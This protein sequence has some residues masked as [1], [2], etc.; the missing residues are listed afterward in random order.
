MQWFF[1]SHVNLTY[2]QKEIIITESTEKANSAKNINISY[3]HFSQNKK[4]RK[5]AL[6]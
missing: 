1:S 6:K 3:K 4:K 5:H 2:L